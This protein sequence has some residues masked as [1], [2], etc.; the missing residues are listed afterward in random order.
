VAFMAMPFNNRLLDQVFEQ[1][2]QPAVE[3]AGF[4]LY[5]IIDNLGAGVIDDQLRVEIR[6]AR[7]LVSDITDGNPG[8]Y[9]EAGFAE[10]A[11]HLYL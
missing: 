1:C 10:G 3:G 7:F 2:F 11:R 8:A 6:K 4:R 5:R 9:W